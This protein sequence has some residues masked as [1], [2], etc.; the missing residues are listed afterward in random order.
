MVVVS[1]LIV[2]IVVVTVEVVIVVVVVDVVVLLVAVLLV[3]VDEH[4]NPH[5]TGQCSC[6]NS[7]ND[8]TADCRQSA[9]GIREPHAAASSLPWHVA[10]LYGRVVVRVVIVVIVV[11]TVEVLE[12]VVTS[13]GHPN[14]LC[15][16]HTSSID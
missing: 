2:V 14:V 15:K 13:S 4:P 10:G 1:V 7:R 12:V 5:I 6:A 9:M 11:V 8:A 16:A 3:V